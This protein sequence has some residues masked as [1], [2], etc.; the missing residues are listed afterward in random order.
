MNLTQWG[1]VS[2]LVAAA[3]YIFGIFLFLVLLDP[4]SYEGPLGSLQYMIENRD[5]FILGLFFTGFV[6]SFALVV[7]VQAMHQ[8]FKQSSPHLTAFA[9]FTGYFWASIVLASALIEVVSI[10]ALT[11][12]YATDPELALSVS[13][14]VNLISGGLG[15]DI[16]IIGALWTGLISYLGIKHRIFHKA[17]HYLGFLVSLA[18]LLTL[19]A[20][21]SMFEESMVFELMTLIFGLG[22]IPWFIW[23]GVELL[24]FR[25]KDTN[26]LN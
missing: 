26:N 22:Q 4:T 21:L 16:E 1:G 8:V 20:F 23:L 18:G 9:S 10:R 5:S 17:L 12:Y 19:M 15:G 7:L 13:K 24:T 25:S 14:A 6:F 11:Q 3:T 2:S